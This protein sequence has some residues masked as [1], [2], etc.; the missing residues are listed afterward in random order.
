MAVSK[1][2][3]RTL[4]V[5]TLA[6]ALGACATT[7]APPADTAAANAGIYAGRSVLDVAIDAAGGE[8]ALAKVKEL[9]WTGVAKITA[10]GKT[11]EEN[12]AVLVRP[13]SFYRITSWAKGAEDKTSKTIQA[14]LGK[15][16]DVTRVTWQPMPEAGAKFENEQLGLLSLMLLTPLKEPGVTIKDQPVGEDGT[17]AIQV[18]REGAPAAELEFDASGKLVRAGYAGT[19]PKTGASVV[20]V[21]S[22][23]GEIVSNGVKWP[24]QIKVERDGAPAFEIELA[25]F[26]ALPTKTVRPLAQAMQ[27]EQGGPVGDD[28][29]G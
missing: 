22:F 18:V 19:N 20:E 12:H 28:D 24:K 2:F 5:G 25:T 1:V 15:A 7:G 8:A 26:E 21:Y 6:A 16:W 4:L 13:F 11:V 14:E 29:A 23:S 10:D 27:Y 9:Y 3:S 17:R